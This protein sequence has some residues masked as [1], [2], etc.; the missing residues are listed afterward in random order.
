MC[1]VQRGMGGAVLQ[2]QDLSRPPGAKAQGTEGEK[3]GRYPAGRATLST[4]LPP[5]RLS[6]EPET[7]VGVEAELT[8]WGLQ[9]PRG[10][11]SAASHRLAIPAEVLCSSCLWE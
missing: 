9:G 5:R 3:P 2:A 1:A 7:G 10:Q 8:F 6:R 11:A 4:Q